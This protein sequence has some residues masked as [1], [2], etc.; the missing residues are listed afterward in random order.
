MDELPRLPLALLLRPPLTA[1]ALVGWVR[2]VMVDFAETL[3]AFLPNHPWLTRIFV[4]RAL[5]SKTSNLWLT[6]TDRYRR[7]MNRIT[8]FQLPF[9]Q[10]SLGSLVCESICRLC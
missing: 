5:H 6:R 10:S 2:I 8:N 3:G 4:K 1:A 9:K 7:R